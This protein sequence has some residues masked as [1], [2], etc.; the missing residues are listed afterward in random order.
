[1]F[2]WV[3]YR[4]TIITSIIDDADLYNVEVIFKNKSYSYILTDAIER[5]ANVVCMSTSPPA[6]TESGDRKRSSRSQPYKKLFYMGEGG[7]TLLGV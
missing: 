5:D 4:I 1:M 7:I 3:D 6:T 2:S